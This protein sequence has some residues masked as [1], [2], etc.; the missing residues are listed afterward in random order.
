[1]LVPQDDLC[2]VIYRHCITQGRH[3]AACCEHVCLHAELSTVVWPARMLA[4][5]GKVDRACMGNAHTVVF[6]LPDILT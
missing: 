6:I 2:Q 1:M 3:L 4:Y 5:A